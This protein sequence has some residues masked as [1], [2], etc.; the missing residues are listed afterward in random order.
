[1]FKAVIRSKVDTFQTF[2]LHR[3]AIQAAE[4]GYLEILQWYVDHGN[5]CMFNPV[6]LEGAALNGHIHVIKWAYDSG[7]PVGCNVLDKAALNGHINILKWAFESTFIISDEKI[8]ENAALNGHLECLMYAKDMGVKFCSDKCTKNAAINSHLHIL[9]WVVENGMIL[10]ETICPIAARNG[11]LDI[12]Q[13]A[14]LNGCGWFHN[15]SVPDVASEHGYL[16]ILKWSHENGA[17]IWPD[18][19]INGALKGGH[20]DIVIWLYQEFQLPRGFCIVELAS[21]YRNNMHI[22]NWVI[23]NGYRCNVNKT[24]VCANAARKGDLQTLKWARS[25]GFTWDEKVCTNSAA[26]GHLEVLQ[27]A[28]ENGCPLDAS[29]LQLATYNGHYDVTVWLYE[30]G[31]PIDNETFSA[32]FINVYTERGY[33]DILKFI[34]YKLN[35]S[36]HKDVWNC[37]VTGGHINIL[38]W[39]ISEK[40]QVSTN[41]Y[42]IA[43]GKMNIEVLKWF[44]DNH[45]EIPHDVFQDVLNGSIKSGKQNVEI[46]NWLTE[47]KGVRFDKSIL[48]YMFRYCYSYKDVKDYTLQWALKKG[49]YFKA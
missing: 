19:C 28:R 39:L 38:E 45:I 23:S 48:I 27:W 33:L 43:A 11:R 37:A 46:L 7:Y 21:C 36:L 1:M 47:R 16:H 5:S 40:C 31:C 2:D 49:H 3:D 14:R 18:A 9:K 42:C 17:E 41:G 12:L 22:I 13:F 4:Y 15:I 44:D 30:H 32:T 25:E 8:C 29:A 20:L 6:T 34:K 24:T 35:I 26:H 10:S